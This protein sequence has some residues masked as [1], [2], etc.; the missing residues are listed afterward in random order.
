[1]VKIVK[2]TGAIFE[3]KGG[4]PKKPA[5]E[6]AQRSSK[7]RRRQFIVYDGES[8]KLPN[9]ETEYVYLA[10]FDGETYWDITNEGG[11]STE[12]C[13]EFLVQVG[14]SNPLAINVIFA[15]TYDANMIIK[16]L[17][18]IQLDNLQHNGRTYFKRKQWTIRFRPHKL[19]HITHYPT[20]RK[21]S[22][23]DVFGFFQTS[24]IK[25]IDAWLGIKDEQIEEGK[26]KRGEHTLEDLP[27]LTSYCRQE[28]KHFHAL[29]LL[30]WQCLND[31]E[32][33]I[34]RWDGAGAAASAIMRQ[35]GIKEYI[36]T[37]EEKKEYYEH[38]TCAY[39]GGRS[40]L[41][42]PGDHSGPIFNYDI[43][44]AYPY[45]ISLLPVFNGLVP[46]TKAN[47]K[48][49]EYDLLHIAYDARYDGCD[50]E[51]FYPYTHR[52]YD[53]AIFFPPATI[54]WHW[55]CEWFACGKRGRVIGHYHWPDNGYRPW[56]WVQQKFE[57]RK[58]RKNSTPYD[59]S[60][61]VIKLALNSLYGKTAQSKGWVNLT[62][63]PITHNMFIAG[64]ITAKCRAMIYEAMIQEPDHIIS[65]QTDGISSSEPLV[66]PLGDGLG[67]WEFK[68]Y[69]YLTAVQAGVYFYQEKGGEP[70]EK[71]RGFDP[72][73]I[74]REAVLEAWDRQHPMLECRS[75]RF[76]TLG[77]CLSSNRLDTH[78]RKFVEGPRNLNLW[79]AARGKRMMVDP[80]IEICREF[81]PMGSNQWMQTFP[82]P[83]T[84]LVSHPHKAA[85]EK[86]KEYWR[87]QSE[88][89]EFLY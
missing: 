66:L 47:C 31:T 3:N 20:K 6:K 5:H 51:L 65:V 38:A 61:K 39:F 10:A 63:M 16:D 52:N 27:E 41:F 77:S 53:G 49:T 15:G 70:K 21:C 32:L 29:M 19:F 33:K 69:D 75:K 78:W 1:V 74:S 56:N 17:N 64:W 79:P 89:E 45:A 76:Y 11:L 86:I 60:E 24:F 4:R 72:G 55:A 46:C 68:Q 50:T 84:D 87:E 25:A 82:R 59:P 9:G 73:T 83:V 22:L 88:R 13:L 7:F 37:T 36:G 23:W 44:S 48:F 42:Q 80:K 18:P 71:Y 54:G 28:L 12:E 58:E 40:E 57:E 30:L 67:E 2:D 34:S 81:P 43:N 14:S 8:V 35:Q 62:D 85:G 26:K